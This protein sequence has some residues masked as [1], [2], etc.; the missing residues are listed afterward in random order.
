M[1]D[2][3]LAELV[4]EY[5]DSED[6]K[7]ELTEY[8]YVSYGIIFEYFVGYEITTLL[9]YKNT[10]QTIYVNVSK[11]NQLPFREYPG[12]KMPLL[13]PRVILITKAGVCE[14]LLKS[15]KRISPDILHLLKT[16][17]I[18]TTNRKCL[19]KEQQTLSSITNM[20]K[21]EKFV[22]QYNVGKYYIDLYFPEYRLCIECDEDGHTSRRPNDEKERMDF[23]NKELEINDKHWLRFNPDAEDFDVY[24][25]I[26]QIL[27]FIRDNGKWQPQY[28]IPTKAKKN[29]NLDS[30]KPCTLCYKIKPL[31]EFNKAKSHR[32]GREN[33]CKLCKKQR[34]YE[35]II[36]DVVDITC[37]LCNKKMLKD[38]F[39]KDKLSHTGHM[40]RCKECHRNRLME[41]QQK[42][43]KIITEK[44]C[45]SCGVTKQVSEFY[46]RMQSTDGYV[47]YCVKCIKQKMT[48]TVKKI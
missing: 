7:R 48:I 34:Q 36:K 19:T 30:E 18:E 24:T 21:T 22:D 14:I 33:R 3:E 37:N 35:M 46:K 27:S 43:K 9:G 16:F 23:V 25:V 47:T 31:E 4:V 10:K 45:K 17:G 13:D 42:P 11:S 29:I 41:I 40:R 39:Y 12:V 6:E 26:R 28:V 38:K 15:R 2:Y 8:T 32:D 44:Q 20:F 5:T 1:I